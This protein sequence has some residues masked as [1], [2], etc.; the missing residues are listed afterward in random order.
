MATVVSS[1]ADT[2][3]GAGRRQRYCTKP[4]SMFK[5]PLR[6]FNSVFV[7]FSFN[8]I[9]MSLAPIYHRTRPYSDQELYSA[10]M[11][12][13]EDQFVFRKLE[14][15]HWLGDKR[16]IYQHKDRY[17]PEL[18]NAGKSAEELW[19][20]R[21]FEDWTTCTDKTVK[22][23]CSEFM[24]KNCL[25]VPKN[26]KAMIKAIIKA[27]IDHGE[28][29]ETI[30]FN[31]ILKQLI[32]SGRRKVTGV[33]PLLYASHKRMKVELNEGDLCY[34]CWNTKNPYMANPAYV[35][36]KSGGS[37]VLIFFTNLYQGKETSKVEIN[38]GDFIN[39]PADELGLTPEQAVMQRF[40]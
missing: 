26:R 32:D 9:D 36:R 10:I 39:A 13:L 27:E 38:L 5:T 22:Y 16:V 21:E 23:I 7:I 20:D 3:D 4:T 24:F 14:I 29:I 8:H 28:L 25:A 12:Y 40:C 11:A 30:K 15:D 31:P 19:H 6:G 1:A 34:F 18:F 2:A 35:Y 37:Y 33:K 17:Q